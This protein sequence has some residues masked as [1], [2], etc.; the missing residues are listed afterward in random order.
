MMEGE[1]K[2]KVETNLIYELKNLDRF[3]FKHVLS[4]PTRTLSPWSSSAACELK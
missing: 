2:K 3:K 4:S 1:I